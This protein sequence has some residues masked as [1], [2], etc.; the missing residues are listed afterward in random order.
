MPNLNLR[1]AIQAE[2]NDGITPDKSVAQQLKIIRGA[3]KISQSQIEKFLHGESVTGLRMTDI[4]K[5]QKLA[6]YRMNK[7]LPL[8]PYKLKI[9]PSKIY[10][11]Y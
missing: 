7:G 11:F 3:K 6:V 10:P 5:F 8:F 9:K 2:G 1:D 4:E